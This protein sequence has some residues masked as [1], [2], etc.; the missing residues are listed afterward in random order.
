MASSLLIHNYG[1]PFP[2]IISF[3]YL[4]IGISVGLIAIRIHSYSY[5]KKLER[6]IQKEID[7]KVV[8]M[9]LC[10]IR[11]NKMIE[12]NRRSFIRR[13][14]SLKSVHGYCM[15]ISWC[16]MLGRLMVTNPNEWSGCRTYP[17]NKCMNNE[18]SYVNATDPTYF[19]IGENNFLLAISIPIFMI[20]FI[21]GCCVS[22]YA[23]RSKKN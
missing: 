21:V 20:V 1:L 6:L 23:S 8:I 19:R 14:F 10:E 12:M 4:L 17:I 13:C 2:I 5:N 22:C 11:R 16:Q 9:D 3:I 7:E 15:V 18:I